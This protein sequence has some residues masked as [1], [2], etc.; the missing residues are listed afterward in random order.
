[1]SIEGEKIVLED[2]LD[3]VQQE[4]KSGKFVLIPRAKNL[5]ALAKHGLKSNDVFRTLCKLTSN[6]YAK[7]PLPDDSGD[8]CPVWIFRK[9]IDGKIFY[10]KIKLDPH[11]GVKCISFH[12]VETSYLL[13]LIYDKIWSWISNGFCRFE[14][15][16]TCSD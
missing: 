11:V 13:M 4:L 2:F 15:W 3:Q 6:D 9:T 10:I 5:Q 8:P 14:K 16:P 12:E 7:G 1:M